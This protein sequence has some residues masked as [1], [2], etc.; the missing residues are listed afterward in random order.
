MTDSVVPHASIAGTDSVVLHASIA[1][2]DS[3]GGDFSR[4]SQPEETA[5]AAEPPQFCATPATPAD[6]AAAAWEGPAA[7]IVAVEPESPAD[8]AGFEPGCYL[9]TVDGHPLRDIIDWRWLASDDVIAV[10]YIDLDGEAGEVELEREPGEDWGFAFDGVLFDTV[11]L[12]R[13]ACVFCFMRQLP[14]GVRPSLVLRDDDFRLS[15]LSGTFVTLTNL[16]PEDEARIVEQHI[17]PLRVSLHASEPNLRRRMIGRHADHGLAALDR[18]LAAGVEVHAQI[19]L[20]PGVNDGHALR[21]TLEWAWERPNINGVGIVPLGFTKHQTALRESFT[22]PESARGVIEVIAP[23]QKR[24]RA[25]RGTP[26]VFAA[27]EFYVNAYG[28][29]TPERIPPTS[30]YGDYD[31]FEDGIGIVRSYVDEFAEA[32]ES[33]LAARAAEELASR[34]LVARYIIGE[35]MQPFLDAMIAASPLAGRLVPLTVCND[36]FGGNVNVTGLLCACDIIA[37]IRNEAGTESAPREEE[38][39]SAADESRGASGGAHQA[40][41]AASETVSDMLARGRGGGSRAGCAANETV[42]WTVSPSEPLLEHV[43]P[44]RPRDAESC[45]QLFL[46]PSVILN[47]NGVTLDDMT[48]QDIENAVG[49]PVHVVSCNPLDYLPEIIALA[50]REDVS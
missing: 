34:N 45:G 13:N 20:M 31:M 1:G 33:G 19:V 49:A 9:T 6:A 21:E 7:R 15:F 17:S 26:W 27:D 14:E 41:S 8:D 11:K 39:K 12:C 23:F 2:T 4:P 18:L 48:V 28:A 36:Y 30:D 24:A 50:E 10:G 3:V 38:E 29:E 35:A 42:Q 5:S 32:C 44:P 16:K 43:P 25:E 47:D 37:A 40:S 46:I 22:S